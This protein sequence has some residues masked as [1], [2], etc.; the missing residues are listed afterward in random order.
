MS[1]LSAAEAE[2]FLCAFLLFFS[3]E[4]SDLDDVYIHGVGIPGFGGGGEGVVGLMSRFGVLFGDFLGALPL[5]LEGNG[6]LIPV[7]NGRGDSVH[8]CD[9]AHEGRRNA[10]G[11]I[12]HEDILVGD[13]CEGGVVFE[14]R[15]ILDEGQ[16]VGV[17]FPFGHSLSGEPDNSVAGGVMVF[18]NGFELRDK[19][20][21][22]PHG[23]DIPRDGVLPKGGCPGEGGSFGHVG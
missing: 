10:G 4:F 23:Y 22:G 6:L 14:V 2:S 11:E 21:E 5:G 8:R 1:R 20:G 16:G 13:V 7:V 3:R 17:V 19:V 15:N 9:S 12:F 18:E